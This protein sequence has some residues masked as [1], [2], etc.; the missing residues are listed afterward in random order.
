M[1]PS[2][3]G[4]LN[5]L[6]AAWA[7]F[8]ETK[9]AH[10]RELDDSTANRQ[11]RL[12][13]YFAARRDPRDL[14]AVVRLVLSREPGLAK[15]SAAAINEYLTALDP[16]EL[17][18]LDE[19]MRHRYWWATQPRERSSDIEPADVPLLRAH[20]IPVLG[21]AS[22][23]ARGYVREAAVRELATS[24]GGGELPYLLI[25][26]NDWVEPVRD[27]AYEEV[28]AR[29]VAAYAPH[30]VR[31]LWLVERLERCGR[32][33]H[34]VLVGRVHGLLTSPAGRPA[35]R[36]GLARGD[37]W[38][39]RSCYRLLLDTPGEDGP[40][41]IRM[42]VRDEDAMIRLRAIRAA[43]VVLD[44]NDLRE[45]LRQVGR[46]PFMPVRREALGLWV[47]HFPDAAESVLRD[48]LLD[49]SPA[50]RQTAR[51]DL[52]ARGA[53]EFRDFYLSAL[54]D[55]RGSRLRP[56]LFGLAETGSEADAA[57]V[58]AFLSHTAPGV[59]RAAVTALSRL[60]P[61]AYMSVFVQALE[62]DSPGVSKAA[63]LALAP[64]AARVGEEKL[65]S[66]VAGGPEAHVRRNA[67]LLLAATGKWNSIGWMI[68]ACRLADERLAAMARQL[69]A[70]WIAR[71]NRVQVQ[72]TRDQLEHMAR[73]LEE[74]AVLDTE[75]E[76]MLRFLM[77]GYA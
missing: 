17:L 9:P 67:L 47:R 33:D 74:G 49:S 12:L 53:G 58:E 35:L 20:G 59:R 57:R 51:L 50:L 25:R 56:A 36:A 68:R 1:E 43:G 18:A 8:F 64:R 39:R 46:D 16:R 70:R 60:D 19:V 55:P 38:L 73:A 48:A 14:P 44:T 42:G 72:P 26:L 34:E 77:K 37:R 31:S 41:I 75:R 66:L 11:R 24:S 76:R 27:A 15:E 69:V 61:E 71:F 28:Q 3:T 2:S 4:P 45:I 40:E 54:E 32:A 13:D 21:L 10:R 62:D 23:H 5:R 52:K 30:F 63:R 29:L 22:F 7:R 65:W 6:R